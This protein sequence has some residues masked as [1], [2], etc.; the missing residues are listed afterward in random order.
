M[1]KNIQSL[2]CTPKADII[3]GWPQS[4]FGFFYN[5]LNGIQ[6]KFNY[7]SIKKIIKEKP[8]NLEYY[9]QQKY[10]SKMKVK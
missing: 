1:Q 3:L 4:S 8:F 10:P 2:C 7:T 9:I 6:F 5:T